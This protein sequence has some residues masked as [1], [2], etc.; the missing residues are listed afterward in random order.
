MIG[1]DFGGKLVAV[2]G[3]GQGNGAAIARG[4][5]QAGAVVAVIDRNIESARAIAQEIRVGKGMAD[6]FELDV[7]DPDACASMSC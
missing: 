1:L 3:A 4:F 6:A 5:A 2:T 7:A